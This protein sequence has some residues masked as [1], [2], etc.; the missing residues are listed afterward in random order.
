MR[1]RRSSVRGEMPAIE[2]SVSENV[3]PRTGATG[4]ISCENAGKPPV[5]KPTRGP[6]SVIGGT[7]RRGRTTP[8][9]DGPPLKSLPH[10]S[11]ARK[12]PTM[13]RTIANFCGKVSRS[14]IQKRRTR[15]AT[16]GYAVVRG[17]TIAIGPRPIAKKIVIPA[18]LKRTRH[19]TASRSPARAPEPARRSD[20]VRRR[21]AADDA[22]GAG[23]HR[24]E[25]EDRAEAPTDRTRG[26]QRDAE[27]R[28]AVPAG[29]ED[30][31]G[32]VDR[33]ATERVQDEHAS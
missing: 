11:V 32:G 10:Q 14:S 8:A 33:R 31:P 13:A 29:P 18:M 6:E 30:E 25:P 12:A 23:C 4:E 20:G 22:R 28:Q 3:I 16:I 5:G 27:R 2:I 26:R 24:A 9:G 21:Q 7:G 1:K 15:I 17:T 19:G